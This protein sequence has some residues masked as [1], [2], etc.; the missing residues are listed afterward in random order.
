MTTPLLGISWPPAAT[1]AVP[2]IITYSFAEERFEPYLTFLHSDY[3]AMD[4]GL[5]TDQMEAFRQAVATW[6]EAAGI[7][8]VLVGDTP[9]VSLRV[10]SALIDGPDKILALTGLWSNA[11]TTTRAA[12]AFDRTDMET[13]GTTTTPPADGELS[14]YQ[15]AL[16]ELGHVLGLGHSA[17]PDDLMY[18]YVNGSITLDADNIAAAVS[19]YGMPLPRPAAPVVLS[20]NEALLQKCYVAYYGRPAD[21]GGLAYWVDQLERNDG[22]LSLI[23]NSFAEAPESLAVYGGLSP[24]EVV[25]KLYHQL[26]GRAPEPEGLTYWTGQLEA[27]NLT[28][29]NIMLTLLNSAQGTDA[30]VVNN[31]LTAA[32]LF[33]KTPSNYGVTPFDIRDIHTWLAGITTDPP[34][35]DA[36]NAVISAIG[37]NL[38]VYGAVSAEINAVGVSPAVD[39][40]LLS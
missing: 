26:L 16:H 5:T 33:T 31:K 8:F 11:S 37:L 12:I 1:P 30:E 21:P 28:R 17:D 14:F 2:S 9:N 39:G 24:A 40:F 23:I 6:E 22:D 20:E 3:P 32:T 19:L 13:A 7:D 35:Q 36:V 29:Q 25:T 4:E 15:L 34:Y 10:G 27:G 38:P 18:P